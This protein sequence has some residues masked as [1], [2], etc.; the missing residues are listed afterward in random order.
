MIHPASELR[1]I[2]NEIG[3]GVV[4]T[5]FIPKGTVTWVLDKLD[6]EFTAMELMEYE[7]PFQ[8]ILSKYCFRNNAGNFVLCWDNGRF[9]NHSFRSNCLSTAYNLEIAV[10]DIQ[11]GEEITDDYGYLNILHP[12]RGIDEGTRRKKVYP[13]D[14][15]KYHKT[16]DKKLL[17]AFRHLSQVDQPLMDIV[18]A[19]TWKTCLEVSRGKEPMQSILDIY[20]DPSK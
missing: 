3:Y 14:L 6:R 1:F 8:Q 4:A 13:D 18:P 5:E 11:P 19:D 15:K 20:Y 2:N 12:F 7:E 10:R 16:W 17:S 9:V